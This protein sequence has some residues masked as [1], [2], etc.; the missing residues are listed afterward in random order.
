MNKQ[1]VTSIKIDADLWKDAKIH[2]I[3]KKMTVAELL[4][5]ALKK[6]LRK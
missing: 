4:N 3:K 2:A 5:T 6:E 1:I